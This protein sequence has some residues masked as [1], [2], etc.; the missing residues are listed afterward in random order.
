[1][2]MD[3]KKQA[4]KDSGEV[5]ALLESWAVEN[6][7]KKYDIG[8]I[9]TA[10]MVFCAKMY[11]ASVLCLL[12]PEKNEEDTIQSIEKDFGEALRY[13]IEYGKGH[14]DGKD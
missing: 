1:M 11:A 7:S 10:S 12:K 9:S 4:I 5:V 2:G 8:A 13:F 6:L 3:D 14:Q